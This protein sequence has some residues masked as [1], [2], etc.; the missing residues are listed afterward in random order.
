MRLQRE[1]PPDARDRALAEADV[2]G[3]RP[4]TPVRRIARSRLERLHDDL[5][6]NGIAQPTGARAEG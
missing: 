3:E 2:L 6:D 1:R 4:R 5:L